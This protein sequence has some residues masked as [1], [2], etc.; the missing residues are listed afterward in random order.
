MSLQ[1]QGLDMI[2]EGLDTLKNM[3]HDMNEVC[4]V[5]VIFSL[6]FPDEYLLFCATH[7]GIGQAGSFDG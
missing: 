3:A 1:D 2:A 7:V 4:A 5:L 6:L